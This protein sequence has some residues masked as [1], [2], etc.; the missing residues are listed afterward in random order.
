MA[1]SKSN[2]LEDAVINH[3]LRNSSVSSPTTV[4]AALFTSVP[5][6]TGGGTE[7]TGGSYARV[8]VTFGAPSPAGTT[9]NSVEVTY[10]EATAG[11]GTVVAFGVFDALTT[12]N[13][14]YWGD[15]TPSKTVDSG[16]TAR[17]AVGDLTIS[18]D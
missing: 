14:L 16:D 8:A 17:F 4:Y 12:G 13:L 6:D 15:I 5:S 10:P 18:E 2:Y 3:F 9:S 1:G 7:V 11:W